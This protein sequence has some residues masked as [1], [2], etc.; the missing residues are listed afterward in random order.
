ML[1]DHHAV[2][3]ALYTAITLLALCAFC[4]PVWG[5][6]TAS[7]RLPGESESD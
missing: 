3:N 2:G 6:L 7:V 5:Q 1:V 4:G